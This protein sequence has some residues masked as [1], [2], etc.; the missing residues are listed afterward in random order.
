MR[1]KPLSKI[2]TQFI[3]T[4]HQASK[5]F[6]HHTLFKLWTLNQTFHFT[7]KTSDFNPSAFLPRTWILNQVPWTLNQRLLLS[8]KTLDFN[9]SVPFSRLKPW[10]LNQVH[11]SHSYIINHA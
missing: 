4:Y 7:A 8:L 2:S 3:F 10:I 11:L 9:P 1:S 6:C 5:I